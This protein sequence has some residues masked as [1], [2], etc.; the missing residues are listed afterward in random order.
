VAYTVSQPRVAARVAWLNGDRQNLG[1]VY[2]L[3]WSPQGALLVSRQRRYSRLESYY[4]LVPRD[5]HKVMV[6]ASGQLGPGALS[7]QGRAFA[8]VLVRDR[9]VRLIVRDL[10]A[11][12]NRMI[13]K[14]PETDGVQASLSPL[15]WSKDGS[16]LFFGLY[17]G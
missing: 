17:T 4:A 16:R 3:G 9:Q 6:L 14:E 15:S 5:L 12:R 10:R 8:F 1:S 2:A 7:P 13:L 11:R